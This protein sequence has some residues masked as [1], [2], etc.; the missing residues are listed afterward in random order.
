[1][2]LY[3]KKQLITHY[4]PQKRVRKNERF[5]GGNRRIYDQMKVKKNY[6]STN[7]KHFVEHY[8]IK[9]FTVENCV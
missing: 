9:L 8:N 1:M 3:A 5:R 4:V 6:L 7:S 2:I